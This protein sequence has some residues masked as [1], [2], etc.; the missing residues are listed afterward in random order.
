MSLIPNTNIRVD[1]FMYMRN[2]LTSYVFFLSHCHEDHIKG[3]HASWNYGKIYCSPITSV[4]ISARFPNLKEYVVPLELDQPHWVYYSGKEDGGGFQVTL[5][6]A[7]HC[8]GA[9]MMLFEGEKMGKVLHTGDFRVSEEML[10][11]PALFPEDNEVLEDQ[12][13]YREFDNFGDKK[14]GPRNR[15]GLRGARDV[16]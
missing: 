14:K 4:L 7:N 15:L 3:L 2:D 10:Q 8:P 11:H 16:K 1:N 6:D 5:I 9:V 13:F 12:T